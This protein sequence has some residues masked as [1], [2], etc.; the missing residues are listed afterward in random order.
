[1]LSLPSEAMTLAEPGFLSLLT[2]GLA[3]PVTAFGD[4]GR[5]S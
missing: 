2:G 4:V 3:M 1:M 5:C